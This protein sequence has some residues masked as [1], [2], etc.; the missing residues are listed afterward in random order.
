MNDKHKGPHC[1]GSCEGA[2]Y[3]IKIRNLEAE[4]VR[5]RAA[6]KEIRKVWAGSESALVGCTT[7]ES[8]LIRLL[9]QCYSMAV[10]ALE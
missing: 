10:G 9:K 5:I 2:A 8:S 3:L 7:Y 6:L 1:A 4:N